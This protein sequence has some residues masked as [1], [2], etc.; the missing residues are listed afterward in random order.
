MTQGNAPWVVVT[1]AA[2]GIGR[3]VATRCVADGWRVL[4][5]DRDGPGLEALAAELGAPCRPA[6]ADLRAADLEPRVLDALGL[7]AGGAD[8]VVHGLANVAGVSQGDAIDRIRDDDWQASMDVNVTAQM[9]LARC[10]LPAL[11]RDEAASIVNVASPVA[12][13]GA[14]KVSYAASK[15]AVLG[16]TRALA[17]NLGPDGIRV[18][19]VHPG[20]TITGMTSD[21]PD[22]KRAA[23]AQESVF[24]RLAR[25]ED[26]AGVIAFLLGPDSR[27]VTGCT[28]DVTGGTL[29]GIHG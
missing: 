8:P 7:D 9:R 17:R 27:F 20:A 4:A 16:L 6:V 13:L 10:L 1:G 15:A 19:A 24:N 28:L 12:L 26:T 5:V 3:A 22:D 18:N 14:R 21:W 23:I 25:P 29:M 11:R 2:S